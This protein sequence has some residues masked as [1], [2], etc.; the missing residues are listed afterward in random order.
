MSS[1]GKLVGGRVGELVGFPNAGDIDGTTGRV[2]GE[3]VLTCAHIL[4]LSGPRLAFSA[5]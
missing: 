3:E 4:A 2:V 5:S 1:D